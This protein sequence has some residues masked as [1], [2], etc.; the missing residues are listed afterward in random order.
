MYPWSKFSFMT[1]F[2]QRLRGLRRDRGIIQ[3][4]LAGR[5][6]VDRRTVQRYEL[7]EIFPVP[8]VLAALVRALGLRFEDLFALSPPMPRRIR[9]QPFEDSVAARE[10]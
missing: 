9:R 5:I 4:D 1:S 3:R 8:E 2:G 10:S 7:G 6:G